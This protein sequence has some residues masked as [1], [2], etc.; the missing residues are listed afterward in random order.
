MTRDQFFDALRELVAERGWRA[1]CVEVVRLTSSGKRV[2]RSLRLAP[3]DSETC[4]CPMTAVAHEFGAIALQMPRDRDSYVDQWD[5]AG[6]ALG[7]PRRDAVL[8]ACAADAE[9]SEAR[10][11]HLRRRLFGACGLTPPEDR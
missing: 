3:P 8:I 5:R 11:F 2:E 10:L 4:H 1:E 6:D 7:L 9:Q